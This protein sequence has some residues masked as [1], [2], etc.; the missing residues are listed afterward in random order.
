MEPFKRILA[1][2]EN[3]HFFV[4]SI[5]K[6]S[7]SYTMQR[8]YIAI[9][10]S[11]LFL[12]C[13]KSD[14]SC[15][16]CNNNCSHSGSD[17]SGNWTLEASRYYWVPGNPDPAWINAN[18]NKPVTLSFTNDSVFAFSDNYAWKEENF[19]RYKLID[20]ADLLI[21]SSNPPMGDIPYHPV[22]VKILSSKEIELT[23]MGI[24]TGTQEKYSCY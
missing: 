10:I 17:V 20:S 8:I 14:S 5:Y 24:D 3:L 4:S 2:N 9:L 1:R 23:Y 22:M 21:Y 19:D 18:P 12:S 7:N 13:V 11:T 6:I 15:S 16:Y